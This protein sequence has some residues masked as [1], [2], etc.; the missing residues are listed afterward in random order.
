M[1][2]CTEARGG[3]SPYHHGCRPAQRA[4]DPHEVQ[5]GQAAGLA[6]RLSSQRRFEEI[7][8]GGRRLLGEVRLNEMLTG[9]H[10]HGDL[11][12]VERVLFHLDSLRS[13]PAA[14][15]PLRP[16]DPVRR[17]RDPVDGDVELMNLGREILEPVVGA[18]FFRLRSQSG[19]HRRPERYI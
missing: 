6:K 15:G 1:T 13:K 4:G 12:L 19:N 11:H 10:V 16:A 9:F 17:N 14:G 18:V 7:L 5:L 3:G 2:E 8:V